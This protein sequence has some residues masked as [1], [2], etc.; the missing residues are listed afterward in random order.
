MLLLFKFRECN[1]CRVKRLVKTSHVDTLLHV[2]FFLVSSYIANHDSTYAIVSRDEIKRK[3]D[4][5]SPNVD[6]ITA[7]RIVLARPKC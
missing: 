4:I 6:L 3:R 7:G 5:H 1:S 2:Y